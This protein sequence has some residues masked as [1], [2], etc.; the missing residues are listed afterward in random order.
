MKTFTDDLKLDGAVS[1]RIFPISTGLAHS[2]RL[3]GFIKGR[4]V[5]HTDY[6]NDY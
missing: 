3:T 5:A 2:I 6:D 4:S 1:E